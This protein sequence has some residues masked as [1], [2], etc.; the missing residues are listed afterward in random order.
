MKTLREL[1]ERE[2]IRRLARLLD[3]GRDVR[4]GIGDDAAVVR[5][6]GSRFDV[7]LTTDA[8]IEGV[9]F[10]RDARPGAI[11]HKAA[12]RVLSDLAAMGAEPLH[13]LTNLVAPPTATWSSIEQMYRGAARI[14]GRHGAAIIGGDTASGP[15]LELHVFGVGRVPEGR[16]VLRSG[17]QPGDAIF[18]TGA[19]GGSLKGRHLAFEPRVREGIFLR[20]WA[21]AMMDVSDGLALDLHRLCRASGVGADLDSERIPVSRAARGVRAALSDGEDFELL[22]TVPRRRA[23]SFERAW[24]RAFSLRCTRIGDLRA[25]RG[26]RLDGR[27]L[28]AGGFEHFCPRPDAR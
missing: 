9:H 2:T 16:A 3:A 17:G 10:R 13:L 6:A 20:R 22:L 19:L 27:P 24:R 11:G 1:G 25:G 14:C 4:T 28:A 12:A 7:V 26:I 5:I 21:T 8:V 23:V 15:L 18:V